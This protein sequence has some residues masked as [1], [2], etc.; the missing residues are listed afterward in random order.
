MVRHLEQS[1]LILNSKQNLNVRSSSW[2]ASNMT[3]LRFEPHDGIKETSPIESPS[4]ASNRIY[5]EQSKGQ[6]KE[7]MPRA[8]FTCTC[9][10]RFYLLAR[11]GTVLPCLGLGL[12]EHHNHTSVITE[13]FTH[14]EPTSHLVRREFE[15]CSMTLANLSKKTTCI[16]LSLSISC[17]NHTLKGFNGFET[18]TY[19]AREKEITASLNSDTLCSPLDD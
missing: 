14:T 2:I 6:E 15:F 11:F 5:T 18:A 10:F 17:L 9:T 19:L 8:R 13:L 16:W 12:I 1:S 3:P 4:T 7:I